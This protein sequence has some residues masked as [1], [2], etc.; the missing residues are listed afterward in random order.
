[1]ALD[2]RNSQSRRG[3][4][5][6]R[7][8]SPRGRGGGAGGGGEVS[9]AGHGPCTHVDGDIKQPRCYSEPHVNSRRILP[10]REL[11]P[12]FFK[13]KKKLAGFLVLVFFSD[14]GF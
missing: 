13:K 10:P 14:F 4:Q 12:N 1:M 5:I 11:V 8:A 7:P 6:C 3:E 2:S 9:P